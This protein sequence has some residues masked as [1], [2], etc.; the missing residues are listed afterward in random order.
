V[1]QS[2]QSESQSPAIRVRVRKALKD[3]AW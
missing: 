3:M 1:L 2:I